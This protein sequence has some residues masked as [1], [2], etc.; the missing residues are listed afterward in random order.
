[1]IQAWKRDLSEKRDLV[2]RFL[3]AFSSVSLP[4][5]KRALMKTRFI[6]A[7]SCLVRFVLQFFLQK[8]QFAKLPLVPQSL[9]MHH[10]SFVSKI[11]QCAHLSNDKNM[12]FTPFRWMNYTFNANEGVKWIDY[13]S[14]FL[15]SNGHSCHQLPTLYHK[16]FK[17]TKT[18]MKPTKAHQI[19]IR[20]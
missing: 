4:N 12:H 18:L 11:Y 3:S 6:S 14:H 9:K 10:R 7:F 19:N 17:L 1:M 15:T 16:N 2:S 5:L 20:Y 8:I 13:S